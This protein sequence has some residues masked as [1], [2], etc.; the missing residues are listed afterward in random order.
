[1]ACIGH[2]CFCFS[3]GGFFFLVHFVFGVL[4]AQLLSLEKWG[5][6]QKMKLK[7][8]TFLQTLKK[9]KGV[10]CMMREKENENMKEEKK[11]NF[12]VFVLLFFK[13]VFQTKNGLK[14]RNF[15]FVV[16]TITLHLLV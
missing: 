12:F 7:V 1:M 2:Q 15:F 5:G 14:K 11:N 16:S 13:K 6:E 9:K 8:Q 10:G 4:L 3:E